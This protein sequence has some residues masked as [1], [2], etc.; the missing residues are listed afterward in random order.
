MHLFYV[1]GLLGVMSIRVLF[2]NL[3]EAFV[4]VELLIIPAHT[5]CNK[6][7]IQHKQEKNVNKFTT[8][9]SIS[10]QKQFVP[11]MPWNLN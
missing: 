3:K 10:L 8:Q 7:R 2:F 4:T 6:L 1:R 9:Q 11:I 5:E